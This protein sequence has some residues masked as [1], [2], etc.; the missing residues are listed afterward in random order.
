[1]SFED[2]QE[3]IQVY[4]TYFGH[5][6]MNEFRKREPGIFKEQFYRTPVQLTSVASV[7]GQST[8]CEVQDLTASG[9]FISWSASLPE[10]GTKIQLSFRLNQ[11]D[12]RIL[13]RVVWQNE[14]RSWP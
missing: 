7:L 4:S 3:L 5:S 12:Y 11:N 1:M 2:K 8:F 10:A 13:G 6:S 14:N 9:C